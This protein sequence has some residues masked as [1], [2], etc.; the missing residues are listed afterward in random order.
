MKSDKSTGLTHRAYEAA[1]KRGEERKRMETRATAARYDRKEK[2]LVLDLNNGAT[3]IV[4]VRLMQEL[5]GAPERSLQKVELGPRGASLHWEDLDV[6]FGVHNLALGIFGGRSWMSELGRKG[7]K[8]TSKAKQAA[9]R[10]NGT[11]GGRPK[12]RAA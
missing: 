6:D 4:P 2:R 12:K 5:A 8:S 3:L 7:G 11:K 10:A 1:V 9:A